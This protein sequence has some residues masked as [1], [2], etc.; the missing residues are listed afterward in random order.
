[1]SSFSI[2]RVNKEIKIIQTKIDSDKLP[3][4]FKRFN[5]T[6]NEEVLEITGPGFFCNLQI[7]SNYPF[8]PYK[9]ISNGVPYCKR[10]LNLYDNNK[11]I[12]KNVFIFFFKTLYLIEPR[13][14]NLDSCYCCL[15]ITCPNLWC[16]S[17]SFVKL[18]FEQLEVRFIEEY[19]S[20][21]RDLKF[22]YDK[23][24]YNFPKEIIDMILDMNMVHHNV[25]SLTD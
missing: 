21:Y 15:S 3:N 16:P 6:V 13:L 10:L 1:M 24:F 4:L 23:L 22:I 12:D 5:F 19:S 25:D 8:R 9:V 7:P 11:N 18:L 14:L 20:K 17:F 2:R